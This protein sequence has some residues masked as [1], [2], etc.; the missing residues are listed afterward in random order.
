M[1]K[2]SDPQTVAINLKIQGFNIRLASLYSLTESDSSEN[3]KD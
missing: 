1:K 2:I 3:K